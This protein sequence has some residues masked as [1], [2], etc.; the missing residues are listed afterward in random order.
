M[1]KIIKIICATRGGEASRNT[2]DYAIQLAKERNAELTFLYVVETSFVDRI[3]APV[4]VDVEAQIERMGDFLLAAVQERAAREGVHA[5]MI[6]RHGPV[7]EEIKN[8]ISEEG[9]DIVVLGRPR[10]EEAVFAETG[11]SPF[12]EELERETGAQVIL[13]GED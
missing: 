13:V 6:H 12:A 7:R 10:G 1:A 2:E 4:V 5:Q 11:V 3:A 9:A 8:C